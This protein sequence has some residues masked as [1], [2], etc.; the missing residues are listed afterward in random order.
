MMLECQ[1]LSEEDKRWLREELNRNPPKVMMNEPTAGSDKEI[2]YALGAYEHVR[3]LYELTHCEN[4]DADGLRKAICD[5]YSLVSEN[6]HR[7]IME[8]R[9]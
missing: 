5:E 8:G 1:P 6:L 4:I 2:I 3:Y 7:A 9:R